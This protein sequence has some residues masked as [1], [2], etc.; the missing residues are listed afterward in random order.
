MEW[1]VS[2]AS[3]RLAGL[4]ITCDQVVVCRGHVLEKPT[5]PEEVLPQHAARMHAGIVQAAR[6]EW[7]CP[8]MKRG[9]CKK[10]QL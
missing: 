2:G 8:A 1:S 6:F 9:V 10:K 4:L 3:G 5:S 7:G